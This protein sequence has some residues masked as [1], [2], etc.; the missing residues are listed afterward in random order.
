MAS[1]APAIHL[2]TEFHALPLAEVLQRPPS[3]LLGVDQAAATQLAS[4]SIGSIFDL[5]LSRVFDA[6]RQLDAAADDPTSAFAR[7]GAPAADIVRANLPG[8][9]RVADLRFLGLD[10]LAG[11]PDPAA[12]GSALGVRTVRDLAVW[13]PY[14]AARE[15]LTAAF[16]PQAGEGFDPE[17]PADLVPKSGE[18]PTERVQYQ[19]LLLDQIQRDASAPDLIDVAGAGFAPV[20]IAPVAQ[21]DFGF[22]GIGLGALLT[23]NQ[24][25]FMH[26]VT[27]G[28]LLHSMALAPGESTRIAVVDWSRKSRAGQSEQVSEAE[29]LLNDTSHNRSI[30]EVTE[31]VAQE[32]Q[33]GFSSTKSKS[34]TKQGGIAAGGGVAGVV[35][36]IGGAL[37]FGG[38]ASKATTTASAESYSTTA[39]S[40]SVGASMLQQVSDRTHQHAHSTR[41]RRASVV[42]EVSQ[43]EHEQISTRVVVNYNH[44]HAMTVQYYEVL[45]LYR[46]ETAVVR[47][48]RAVFVPFRLVDFAAPGV[49]LR[50][51]GALIDAALTQVVRD[52]LVN[53]DTLELAPDRRVSFPRLGGTIA[54]VIANPSVLTRVT[55]VTLT[56]AP[57][58]PAPSPAPAPV[59]PLDPG[60]IGPR[61]ASISAISTT[62]LKGR[63][64]SEL[65]AL[66]ASRLSVLL[67]SATL[68]QGSESLFVP[69]DVTVADG[70]V[71]AATTADR[72]LTLV[73]H[74]KDGSQTTDLSGVSFPLSDVT[75]IAI[76][77]SA[78]NADVV[79]GVMLTLARNGVVFPLE[80]PGVTLPRGSTETRLVEVRAAGA[81]VN[82][83]QHLAD[84]RL[85]YS[86]A[87]WR[88]LDAAM[89]AG[90]LGNFAITLNNQRVNLAQ[91]IDP[92]PIRIVGN[93]LAFRIAADPAADAEWREFLRTRGIALGQARVEFVPL[94]SG[95]VFAEAVLGRFNC[96]EKLDITRF[97]NWQDSPIPMQA[98]DIA[99]ISAGSRFQAD[100]TTAG[101]FAA[102]LVQ[103]QQP[104]ALPDPTGMAGVLA[105]IQNGAMFRDMS[106][107]ADTI[108]L[109][110]EALKA[111]AAG[112]TAAGAQASDN[113]KHSITTAAEVFKAKQAAGGGAGKKNAADQNT[114]TQGALINEQDK[115]SGASPAQTAA[116][117]AAGGSTG[118]TG[119]GGQ[120][121]PGGTGGGVSGTGG[122]GSLPGLS[123]LL[124]GTAPRSSSSSGN[125]ALDVATF[126]GTGK[127][128]DEEIRSL[129]G[130][131]NDSPVPTPDTTAEGVPLQEFSVASRIVLRAKQ[132]EN[133]TPGPLTPQL[134][135]D[136]LQKKQLHPSSDDFKRILG[137]RTR[138]V[139]NMRELM[140]ELAQQPRASV[141]RIV[142]F[143]TFGGTSF[144]FDMELTY[145]T[146]ASGVAVDMLVD[147]TR[148][149]FGVPTILDWIASGQV[150]GTPQGNTPLAD[151]RGAFAAN[152]E[153]LL[154]NINR[155]LPTTLLQLLSNL[156]GV[157]AT[158]F[159]E[160][161]TIVAE[162]ITITEQPALAK[163]FKFG[164]GGSSFEPPA[165][166]V[167]SHFE[168]LDDPRAVRVFPRR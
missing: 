100:N 92:Q 81:D 56:P 45:Q 7:F 143:T 25:W 15:I 30:S 1:S 139:T 8:A 34:T 132:G 148:F 136:L 58:A 150:D 22:R 152:A 153:L 104:T 86:Q 14:R 157:R 47:A 85:H 88:A 55:G 10:V 62:T 146:D 75:A 107:L 69:A 43:T 116:V 24:S 67:G 145:V 71:R 105:A 68:R 129:L 40:R 97:W 78:T 12:L 60:V 114:S 117:K 147:D 155:G 49:L 102:P 162:A 131:P 95:G 23:F 5:A 133:G 42:R 35:G 90:L 16:F 138:I 18:F 26:G 9:T 41:T 96:A 151:V 123:G 82:L 168:L 64:A 61:R 106:G 27:L 31:A 121:P 124:G 109:A 91:V 3:A 108:K 166:L 93:F 101:A 29:S 87:V 57:P 159:T 33:E 36:G 51:R 103:L 144:G 17:A 21:A 59:T 167:F 99:A 160:P 165:R 140:F 52:A 37:G 48:D 130:L 74:R 127:P 65:W 128:A 125:P 83:V 137:S 44:M 19:T 112:A 32:A 110:N 84:N 2:K 113:F 80:L 120:T 122:G 11:V 28:H 89:L 149:D 63:V 13:P 111:S 158:G 154:F 39:G 76:R 164:L 73:L 118:A 53:F 163:S 77:G 46:I 4:L 94:S 50:F 38:S 66:P 126:G 135:E 134:E 115:R 20:D 70:E 142:L 98:S 156:L 6:A 141:Q 72:P 79:A 54:D 119:G 161:V